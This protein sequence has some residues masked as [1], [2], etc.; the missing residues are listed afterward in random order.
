MSLKIKLI[1]V[2]FTIFTMSCVD[3]RCRFKRSNDT[4]EYINQI[5][6][7]NVKQNTSDTYIVKFNPPYNVI[8][9]RDDYQNYKSESDKLLY[10]SIN[11]DIV[12]SRG[13][14]VWHLRLYSDCETEW[15]KPQI[16]E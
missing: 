8:N 9:V 13:D 16:A 2:F 5:F 11:A 4:V 14:I 12:D 10:G 7:E 15:I 3:N 6:N 1:F